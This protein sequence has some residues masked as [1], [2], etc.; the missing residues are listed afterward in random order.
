MPVII[1]PLLLALGIQP[2][3]LWRA[4]WGSSKSLR[5]ICVMCVFY[6]MAYMCI[7]L[8]QTGLLSYIAHSA[9]KRA[10]TPYE[11]FV[12][13]S[14][15]TA[16]M[17]LV[18]SNDIVI[19]TL[20]PVIVDL[21]K[22]KGF[23]PW[24]ML[25]VQFITANVWS[26]TLVIGNPTNVVVAEGAQLSFAEYAVKL[27][28]IGIISGVVA[29]A[30]ISCR[31]WQVLSK[32]VDVV[33][34]VDIENAQRQAPDSTSE[35]P[36]VE[37]PHLLQRRAWICGVRL[38]LL[39]VF[40]ALDSVHKVPLWASAGL[41][42]AGSCLLDLCLDLVGVDGSRNNTRLTVRSLPWEVLP[43]AMTLFFIVEVLDS[44][45]LVA[46]LANA[47]AS[48]CGGSNWQTIVGIGLISTLASQVLNN[49]P[50]T[51]LFT[52]ILLHPNFAS[53]GASRQ[54]AALQALAS[55]SNLGANVTLIGALA[56]P[57]WISVLQRHGLEISACQFTAVMLT[58]TPFVAA[59]AFGSQILLQL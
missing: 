22:I 11:V 17:T 52:K 19:L 7:S 42:A 40:A 14:I 46:T 25:F 27:A 32:P 44:A 59:A 15:L 37:K 23:D 13:V 24:P 33:T 3:L 39:L 47:L 5:P 10:R 28:P 45:G 54:S 57:M 1:V 30:T 12:A 8:D 38:S 43:F 50:M 53:L 29:V 58:I 6:G 18:T 51:V 20:T 48:L 9:A 35:G 34:A 2:A 56:G 4:V 55:G 21:C 41:A 31:F 16:F 26:I 49:Q 36:Q